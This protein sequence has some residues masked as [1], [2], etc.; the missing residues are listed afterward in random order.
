ML[1]R[2]FFLALVGSTALASRTPAADV[3]VTKTPTALE[4]KVGDEVITKYQY[5]GTVQVEK[6]DGTKPLAKPYF[7]PLNAPGGTC[8]TRPWPM[9]RGTQGETTDHFHQKSAWFCHG[10][11]IPEGIDLKTKSADKHV[12][13]V[14]FWAES[15][16]HGRIVCTTVGEPKGGQVRTQ[17]E[18]LTPD[19]VKILD[20]T[21]TL[22][23]SSLPVGRLIV[24]DIDLTA[25]V[26]PITFGDTKEGSMGVRVSD[27]FRLAKT[28]SDG[29]VTTVDGQIAKAPAKDNLPMWGQPS[30]WHDYSGSVGG[31]TVGLAIFEDPTNKY[32]AVWHTRAYGL[33]AANPFGRAGSGFPAM[34]GNTDLVKLAKGQRLTLRYGLYVHTG[35]TTEGKVAEAF[36]AF[37]K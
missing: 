30:V 35:G 20:E 16:G 29:V 10:D 36:T 11:V 15:T 27:E 33:M 2:Y 34:K 23:V 12:K 28:G 21:R 25:S 17:N 31:K 9:I 1:R 13:G 26:C 24:L 8:A 14:D 18:W 7:Y 5:A 37:K 4:F 22:T 6:G 19:G 32:P 3:T